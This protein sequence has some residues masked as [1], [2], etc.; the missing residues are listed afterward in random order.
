MGREQTR[1]CAI[2]RILQSCLCQSRARRTPLAERCPPHLPPPPSPSPLLPPTPTPSPL[3]PTRLRLRRPRRR[4]RLMPLLSLCTTRPIL[5]SGLISP[6]PPTP[7]LPPPLARPRPPPSPCRTSYAPSVPASY[8]TQVAPSVRIYPAFH[9][10]YKAYAAPPG[11]APSS[12]APPSSAPS[13][14]TSQPPS[15]PVRA[16]SA[17]NGAHVSAV[18]VRT[19]RL[20]LFLIGQ[21][22]QRVPVSSLQ[23]RHSCHPPHLLV[24]PG[25][26][27]V[28]LPQQLQLRLPCPLR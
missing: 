17:A 6:I 21:R 25:V 13:V 23:P 10:T 28:P 2:Y 18:L 7:L 20:R 12:S 15:C 16:L 19:L 22:F 8:L 11:S 24:R 4:P 14:L 5:T 1:R 9:E 27:L 3:R 26:V